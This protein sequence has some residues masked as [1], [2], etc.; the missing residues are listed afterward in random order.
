MTG[1]RWRKTISSG[2]EQGSA[3][4]SI[5]LTQC[6]LTTSE[7]LKANGTEIHLDKRKKIIDLIKKYNKIN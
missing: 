6:E 3:T 4:T 1:Q 7:A 2:G 5:C